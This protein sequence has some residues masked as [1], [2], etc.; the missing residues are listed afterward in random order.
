[1]FLNVVIGWRLGSWANQWQSL[2]LVGEKWSWYLRLIFES[3]MKERQQVG[4]SEMDASEQL[5][6]NKAPCKGVI[7]KDNRARSPAS[8]PE[9]RVVLWLRL[10]MTETFIIFIHMCRWKG[11]KYVRCYAVRICKIKAKQ[12]LRYLQD[13]LWFNILI[14]VSKN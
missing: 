8:R 10:Q 9:K 6:G 13:T 1:M 7:H 2:L 11:K 4:W 3:T 5:T 12:V 14:N